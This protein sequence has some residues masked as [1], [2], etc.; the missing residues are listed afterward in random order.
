MIAT[1][2]KVDRLYRMNV[3]IDANLDKAST[4]D[5]TIN[6][7]THS[8]PPAFAKFPSGFPGEVPRSRLR[9]TEKKLN[10]SKPIIKRIR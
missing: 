2:Q 5:L 9:G 4:S 8:H 3:L 6:E 1:S 10:M 7:I